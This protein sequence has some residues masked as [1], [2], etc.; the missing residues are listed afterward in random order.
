MAT[1][2]ATAVSERRRWTTAHKLKIVSESLAPH[3]SVTEVARRHAWVPKKTAI[4]QTRCPKSC[5]LSL[6]FVPRFRPFSFFG[7]CTLVYPIATIGSLEL[8]IRRGVACDGSSTSFVV[9]H[10]ATPVCVTTRSHST[11]RT[12]ANL[13]QQV[14]R[15]ITKTIQFGNARFVQ[16]TFK[17]EKHR[18]PRAPPRWV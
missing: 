11:V 13:M 16:A 7:R 2:A 6:R 5:T 17:S 14:Y 12:A 18:H 10:S 15:N 9:S 1:D 4:A 8:Q 3:A